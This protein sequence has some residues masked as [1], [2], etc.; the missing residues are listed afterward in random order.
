MS[1]WNVSALFNKR[2]KQSQTL[3]TPVSQSCPERP[4]SP[5]NPTN[6]HH[7]TTFAPLPLLPGR[8]CKGGFYV[9]AASRCYMT[10]VMTEPSGQKVVNRWS[11]QEKRAD[12]CSYLWLHGRRCPDCC[13]TVRAFRDTFSYSGNLLNIECF[14]KVALNGWGGPPDMQMYALKQRKKWV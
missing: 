5:L 8:G 3:N 7:R 9:P 13:V 2:I 11:N 4:V 6:Q 12:P 1:K 14:E 10:V